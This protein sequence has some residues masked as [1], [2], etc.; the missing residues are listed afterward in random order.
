MLQHKTICMIENCTEVGRGEI[1]SG[2][3]LIF[4]KKIEEQRME[5][6]MTS[7]RDLGGGEASPKDNQNPFFV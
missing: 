4:L 5:L 3:F 6:F 2:F 7:K 1:F